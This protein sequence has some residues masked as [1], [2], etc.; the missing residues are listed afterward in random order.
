MPS[1]S[2]CFRCCQYPKEPRCRRCRQRISTDPRGSYRRR[3]TGSS[4]SCNILSGIH[5]KTAVNPDAMQQASPRTFMHL[6]PPDPPDEPAADLPDETEACPDST[7]SQMPAPA[8]IS[9]TLTLLDSELLLQWEWKCTTV[10]RPVEQSEQPF[11]AAGTLVHIM[12]NDSLYENLASGGHPGFYG[13][14]KSQNQLHS[15]ILLFLSNYTIKS[16]FS[17]VSPLPH[18]PNWKMSSP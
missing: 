18:P 17:G 6:L 13:V 15:E 5:N 14:Q 1:E 16:I 12:F 11:A 8:V 7:C 3:D 9:R 10:Q 2:Y 4:G